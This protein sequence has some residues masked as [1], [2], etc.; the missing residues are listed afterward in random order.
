MQLIY[1]ERIPEGYLWEYPG[2]PSI[3]VSYQKTNDFF[4]SVEVGFVTIAALEFWEMGNK[5]LFSFAILVVF[6]ESAVKIILRANYIIDI[7]SGI[8]LAHF[9]YIICNEYSYL[10]DNTWIT[11]KTESEDRDV[12]KE[13]K[14]V[15][16]YK[17]V[18]NKEIY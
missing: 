12:N 16:E 1:Q 11:L 14:D 6:V 10:L 8:F 2:F 5:Y 3:F 13:N 4:F 7:I 17:P 9:I 18:N 15:N